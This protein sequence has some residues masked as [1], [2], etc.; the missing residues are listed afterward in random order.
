MAQGIK[1]KN[2]PEEIKAVMTNT[3]Q[4]VMISALEAMSDE[5]IWKQD[6]ISAPTVA[7]I[8]RGLQWDAEYEKSVRELVPGIDYQMWE[9]VSHFLMMDDPQKF[10][11]TV[12]EFLKKN[13][14]IE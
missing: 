14:L 6:K 4:Y 8:A 1:N 3:L 13:N 12:L 5:A 7:V 2:T 11:D 9:G 10:N